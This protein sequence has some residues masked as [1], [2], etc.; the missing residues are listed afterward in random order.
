MFTCAGLTLQQQYPTGGQRRGKNEFINSTFHQL[1]VPSVC[2]RI[3]QNTSTSSEFIS[4]KN[5]VTAQSRHS[6]TFYKELA[7]TDKRSYDTG[8]SKR[9]QNP[10]YFAAKAI[11][12]TKFLSINQRSIRPCGSGGPGHLKK[13]AMV[14]SDPKEDQF[15]SL[16]FLV[17]KK[18]GRN[19][20]AINLKD[21]NSNIPYQHFKMEGLLL[22]KEMLLPGDKMCKIDL[23]DAYF[24]IP[25]SVK[26]RK[27]VRFQ[28]KGFLY[29]FFLPLLRAFSS[30][31]LSL[32]K[33]QCKNNNLPR[34]HATNGIFIRGLV[35]GKR[36]T[37]IH[38]S[39][40]RVSD[41]YQKVLPRA[42]ID[43]RICRGDS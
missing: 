9:L 18:E 11:K 28:W 43:F 15:L 14:V 41:Q 16:L 31:S 23:K 42:K 21:L 22:L 5:Q 34:R 12:A 35:D 40:L 39:T 38:T 13:D 26:S 8:Y 30:S 27:Y 19:H 4:G 25:L 7:Q 10:F 36:Y 32:E 37:D 24:A 1:D 17:K 3:L 2:V 33:T 20:P 6:E 29:E